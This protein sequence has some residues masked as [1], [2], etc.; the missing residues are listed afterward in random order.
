MSQIVN[1]T[2][3]DELFGD[4][5]ELHECHDRRACRG[6]TLKLIVTLAD[7]TLHRP[8][9]LR[10]LWALTALQRHVLTTMP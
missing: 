1:P 10:A 7:A 9:K 5:L 4:S 3:S 6:E 8:N 2:L